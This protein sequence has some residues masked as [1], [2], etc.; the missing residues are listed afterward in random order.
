[1]IVTPPTQREHPHLG[2]AVWEVRLAEIER[3]AAHDRNDAEQLRWGPL[4]RAA[5]AAEDSEHRLRIQ[6]V[7]VNRHR[8]RA[9]RR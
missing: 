7:D 6:V 1:M 4:A 3:D 8:R 2:D 5:S 9:G